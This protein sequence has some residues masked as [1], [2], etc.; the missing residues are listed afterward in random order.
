ML[1]VYKTELFP[2]HKIAKTTLAFHQ[3]V[4]Y[5]ADL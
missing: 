4:L 2:L 1:N 3:L 5:G